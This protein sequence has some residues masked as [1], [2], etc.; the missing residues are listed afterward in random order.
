MEQGK[1]GVLRLEPPAKI[2][3]SLEVAG[4]RDDGYHEIVTRMCPI[5]LRDELLVRRADEGGTIFKAT[6]V[7]DVPAGESN[8]VMRAVRVFEARY[9]VEV[10]ACIELTKRIPSGAGLGGGSSDAA[11]TLLALNRLMGMRREVEELALLGAEVGSDV[12]FFVY[13]SVCDCRGR[14]ECVEKVP[15]EWELP[16]VLVKPAFA[17]GSGWAYSRWAGAKELPGISYSPQLS[18]WGEMR[19]DLERPVFEKHLV[20]AEMKRWLLA[21]EESHAVLMSGSG[22]TMFAVLRDE[23]LGGS[24]VEKVLARYGSE[25]WTHIGHTI[26]SA[27]VVA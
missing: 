16:I 9:G 1:D 10:H 11:S 19:N 27:P 22:S 7:G 8:L 20:L 3:L 14:G 13:E 5:S 4:R 26:A 24:L 6:G 12:S 18:Y 2:N 23:H 21:Q 25:T 15:F 17:V